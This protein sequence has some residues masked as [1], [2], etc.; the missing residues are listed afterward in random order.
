MGLSSLGGSSVGPLI[1]MGGASGAPTSKAAKS[2]PS[3][4]R[5]RL[6]WPKK[7]KRSFIKIKLKA[8]A[9]ELDAALQEIDHLKAVFQEYR[10]SSGY[11]GE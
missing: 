3:S 2:C 10:E 6:K 11:L 1:K 4:G 5:R 9:E 7:M 8:V